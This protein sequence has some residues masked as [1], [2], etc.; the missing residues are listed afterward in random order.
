MSLQRLFAAFVVAA[1][2]AGGITLIFYRRMARRP[3]APAP[4]QIVVAIRD[5]PVGAT[6]TRND[7]A[8]LD[9]YGTS[10]PA[11]AFTKI[12]SSLGRPVRSPVVAM[13]PI[14]ERD[15]GVAGAGIGLAG[16][17]PVGM[18]AMTVRS[19]E[20]LGVAG[21]LYRGSHVDCM[22][23]FTLPGGKFPQAQTVLQNIEVLAVGQ[24]IEP[25]P[26]SKPQKVNEVTLLLTPEDSL[27]LELASAQGNIQFV[28]R[29]GADHEHAESLPTTLDQV[30]PSA[31]PAPVAKAA[32]HAPRQPAGFYFID[33]I[34]GT[35][36]SEEKVKK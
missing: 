12:E 11:G 7:V 19:N 16:I 18:R 13:L 28:L 1:L 24:T 26:Q 9:W 21:F 29:S 4:T 22:V 36:R 33:V 15:L 8:L 31:K 6:L 27:K 5:L 20:I 14:V 35:E 17:I 25:D 30:F 2:L 32:R 34:R 3:Q 23:T 10:L